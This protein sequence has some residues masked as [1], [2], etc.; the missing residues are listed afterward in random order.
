M[1]NVAPDTS[2]WNIVLRRVSDPAA[3]KKLSGKSVVVVAASAL[4]TVAG[5]ALV[6]GRVSAA[7]VILAVLGA[8]S[9]A[10]WTLLAVNN[11][12]ASKWTG[13]DLIEI[14]VADEGVIGQGGTAVTWDEIS[15]IEWEW[16]KTQVQGT[17][18]GSTVGAAAAGAA[19]DKAGIDTSTKAI[20]V[21]LKDFKAIKARTTSKIQRHALAG[22]MLGDP[23]YLHVG[24]TG[25]S[26]DSFRELISVLTDQA[27]RHGVPL[28]RKTP[29]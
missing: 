28:T 27:N 14:L 12:A 5:I 10:I 25:N 20:Q 23:G 9:L 21:R 7:G 13:D 29:A 18:V 4:L 19:F 22:P 17:S 24:Q 6:V 3:L 11:Y 15:D 16:T 2:T 1:T 8:L 26:E